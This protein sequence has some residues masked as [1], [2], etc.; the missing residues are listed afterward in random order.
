MINT[1][2]YLRYSSHS[3]REVSIEQQRQ[4][5]ERYAQRNSMRIVAV[6]AD[7]A[8]SGRQIKKRNDFQ[9]MLD[10]APKGL[11]EAVLV[12]QLDR[13]ARNRRESQMAKF[14]L[15]QHG[16][17][18]ISALEYISDDP[19]GILIESVLEGYAE[20]YSADLSRKIRR[21][22]DWNAHQ[23]LA[24]GGQR[25]LGYVINKEKRYEI[26]PL[27]AP[28]VEMIFERYASGY[29]CTE[30]MNYL[31]VLGHKTATG[32][33]FNKNSI[34]RILQNKKYLGYYTYKGEVI[35]RCIPQII[36]DELF[37][38]VQ[39]ML[40]RNGQVPGKFKAK[41][42][43]LL[44]TKLFCGYCG[45]MMIGT[46]GTSAY[47]GKKYH[48]YECPD[49]RGSE[50]NCTKKRI[51]KDKI[52]NIIVDATVDQVLTD[53]MICE[54]AKN[55]AELCRKE[56]EDNRRIA[57]LEGKIKEAERS[58]ENLLNALELAPAAGV[59]ARLQEREQELEDLKL[60]LI[61]AKID[62]PMITEKQVSDFLSEFKNGDRQEAT[63]RHALI[64]TLIFKAQLYE[65]KVVIYYTNSKVYT[66]DIDDNGDNGNKKGTTELNSS[67]SSRMVELAIQHTNLIIYPTYSVLTVYLSA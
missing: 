37:E 19:S 29:S 51:S 33:P 20:F 58:V 5:C 10:D 21:G 22:M 34:R 7:R 31:N 24:I 55:V 56:C 67:H 16:I 43:F 61:N 3:Q 1:V 17:R 40:K 6:Y 44:S 52:E 36:S 54:I 50:R 45:H 12:Y 15:K 23:G 8:I 39:A 47:K 59:A 46:T 18:V 66:V 28:I 57:A 49:N 30:V 42:D 27:T 48:Y 53:E 26:D 25:M 64:D 65:E 60:E 63:Y 14:Y 9:Q 32:Q 2:L 11:F 4:E 13:F 38:E 62:R 35:S 41:T